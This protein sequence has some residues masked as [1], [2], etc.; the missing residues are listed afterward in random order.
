MSNV[1]DADWASTPGRASPDRELD[2]PSPLIR[3]SI[4][5]PMASLELVGPE[6]AAIA[7]KVD[8]QRLR[9][10]TCVTGNE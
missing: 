6:P 7:L 9:L 3:C 5:D 8:S 2:D 10:I 4:E 1:A